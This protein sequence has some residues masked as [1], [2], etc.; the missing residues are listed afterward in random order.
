MHI[1]R[2]Q[3]GNDR[4]ERAAVLRP[5]GR[6]REG[7]AIRV[8]VGR[9]CAALSERRRLPSEPAAKKAQY[10]RKSSSAI[11]RFGTAGQVRASRQNARGPA[12][13]GNVGLEFALGAFATLPL[14]QPPSASVLL[15]VHQRP[16]AVFVVTTTTTN[17]VPA[18][19][20]PPY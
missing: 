13:I 15:P 12:G 17:G 6:V 18:Y 20:A 4:D 19:T 7:A 16:R 1:I 5:D 11:V 8:A 2:E 14:S 3:V 10:I 9:R